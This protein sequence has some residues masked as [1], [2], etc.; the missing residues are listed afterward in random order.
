M[1][2][3]LGPSMR[4]HK[5]Q[6]A[7]FAYH[8][9][10]FP[11][12]IAVAG[13]VHGRLEGQRQLACASK[14]NVV[15]L[16]GGLALQRAVEVVGKVDAGEGLQLLLRHVAAEQRVA[17]L[18]FHLRCIGERHLPA[19]IPMHAHSLW[20]RYFPTGILSLLGAIVVSAGPLCELLQ[21]SRSEHHLRRLFECCEPCQ[22]VVIPHVASAHSLQLLVS[23]CALILHPVKPLFPAKLRFNLRFR[24]KQQAAPASAEP[25]SAALPLRGIISAS[26]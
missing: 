25:F 24:P 23:C 22:Y 12:E 13:T 11:F 2:S 4:A 6:L 1:L 7:P 16:Q 10:P 21:L 3:Q 5:P 26:L 20:F 14:K 9:F 15:R 17:H 18:I 8:H 19:Q